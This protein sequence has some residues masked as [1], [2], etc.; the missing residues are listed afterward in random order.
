MPHYHSANI[1][2]IMEDKE[3]TWVAT[4][5]IN[6]FD[7][8][9]INASDFLFNPLIKVTKNHSLHCHYP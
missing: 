1:R 8:I 7:I 5:K 3:D 9:L 2:L 6:D 4:D